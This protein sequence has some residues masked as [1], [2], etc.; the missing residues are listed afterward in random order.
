MINICT[1]ECF[2]FPHLWFRKGILQFSVLSKTIHHLLP[3]F[4]P[5]TPKVDWRGQLEAQKVNHGLRLKK[6]KQQNKWTNKK[7][8]KTWKQ[9]WY[10]KTNSK[11]K[12]MNDKVHKI[13]MFSYG[14]RIIIWHRAIYFD[15]QKL[16]RKSKN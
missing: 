2:L 11:S 6:K 14:I 3:A 8:P 9:Q 10:N 16:I 13:H 1:A 12:N 4:L 5:P 7:N 15:V